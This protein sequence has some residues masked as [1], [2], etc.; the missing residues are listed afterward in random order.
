[1]PETMQEP[2]F[3]A[4]GYPAVETLEA[5]KKWPVKSRKECHDLLAFVRS[6]W[7]YPDRWSE[8]EKDDGVFGDGQPAK[9]RIY[10]MSTGG[11]SG[12]EDLV[13]AMEA[14]I[15]FWAISLESTHR[16][17][18]YIFHLTIEGDDA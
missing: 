7:S 1:M 17:G 6:A 16:G 3:E 14:N 15:L 8:R 5:I 4:N 10:E 11:W 18:L 9:I 13:S 2:T 12:N